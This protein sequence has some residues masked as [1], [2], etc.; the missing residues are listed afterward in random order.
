MQDSA[1]H[2]LLRI[3]GMTLALILLFD[4]GLLSPVT[5]EV[6]QETQKYLASAIGMYAGVEPTELNQLTA[7]LSQRDRLL[8]ERENNVS[9]REIAVDLDG[10]GSGSVDYSS[11]ILSLLLFVVL[12]LIILN[13]VFDYI[14]YR[15]LVNQKTNE[16]MA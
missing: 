3:A 14:R 12:V 6:S 1:Y 16:Q 10:Q 9:A 11:Y 7:E 2:S 4:S 8:T 13:Y 15:Q 5:Q